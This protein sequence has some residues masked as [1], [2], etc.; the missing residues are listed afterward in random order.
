M[1][2]VIRRVRPTEI[3]AYLANPHKG[4]CTF[5][6]FNGDPLFGGTSWSEQGPLTFPDRVHPG[7][8]PGY[9]PSTVSYCRWYWQ[10]L[11]PEQGRYEFGIVEQ[12]LATAAA[13]GQTLA[14]RL[15]PFGHPADPQLP[16]WY[17]DKHGADAKGMPDHD[18]PAYLEHFGGLIRATGRLYDGDPRLESVDMSYIG[19]WGEGAGRCSAEQ[20]GRF[21]AVFGEAFPHTPRLGM[22][23]D[24]QMRAAL[25]TGSGWRCDCFGDLRA[26]GNECVMRHHSWNHMLEGYPRAMAECNAVDTWKTAPVH[27]ETC[28]V[29]TTWQQR[30]FDLDYIIAQG[31]KWHGT[32]FMP[33]SCAMSPEWIEKLSVFCRR[34][35]YRYVLRHAALQSPATIAGG[36]F[37]FQAFIEN[38]GVAP[39]YHR[40]D[41]AIRFRQRD[42]EEIVTVPD[43]DIRTWLPGDAWIDRKI[44]LP[45]GLKPGWVDVALGIVRPGERNAR[46]RFAV[47]EDFGNGWVSL[48]GIE[49]D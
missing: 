49:L 30:E 43:V 42:R 16:K 4:A 7:V 45:P 17:S 13:R 5:Q 15:M 40:Y 46:V 22:M 14:I 12:A 47:K 1:S 21:A 44:P 48:H 3:D 28:W 31:L 23:G 24:A 25:A 36:S 32:Y 10:M 9:L 41:L 11:E 20:C 35:G 19:Y 37:A 33:K 6:R 34:L 18:S 26:P 38:V 2:E 27:F 8:T 29:P 39:I